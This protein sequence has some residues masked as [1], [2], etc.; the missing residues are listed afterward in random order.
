MK[1]RDSAGALRKDQEHQGESSNRQRKGTPEPRSSHGGKRRGFIV[2][3]PRRFRLARHQQ[4]LQARAADVEQAAG[5]YAHGAGEFG[6]SGNKEHTRHGDRREHDH[7]HGEA[8]SN[9]IAI[10]MGEKGRRNGVEEKRGR[11]PAT[12]CKDQR[13]HWQIPLTNCSL[14]LIFVALWLDHVAGFNNTLAF[15]FGASFLVNLGVFIFIMWDCRRKCS[16]R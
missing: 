12:A 3:L 4:A 8:Q 15:A 2:A 7:A 11:K 6:L 16:A 14:A 5:G 10:R 9:E 1:A 13:V